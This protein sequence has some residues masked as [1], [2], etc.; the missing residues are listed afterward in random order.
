P[1]ADEAAFDEDLTFTPPRTNTATQS[2]PPPTRT[3]APIG[4][5]KSGGT[6]PGTPAPTSR[7]PDLATPPFATPIA[8]SGVGTGPR[9]V[10]SPPTTIPSIATRPAGTSTPLATPL[11]ARSTVATPPPSPVVPRPASPT[12]STNP[13]L[14]RQTA[15]TP[16]TNPTVPRTEVTPLP[17]PPVS[18]AES[19]EPSGSLD[20][21]PSMMLDVEPLRRAPTAPP[22]PPVKRPPTAPPASVEADPEPSSDA[23]TRPTPQPNAAELWARSMAPAESP[24]PTLAD[25]T[26]S[27]M[28][29][30][31]AT[32]TVRK[33]P[34][35]PPPAHLETL[36]SPFA[37]GQLPEGD[38]SYPIKRSGFGVLLKIV[39]GLGVLALGFF[40]F[41]KFYPMDD[42]TP[43]QTAAVTPPAPPE[44][45]PAPVVEAP[46]VVVDAPPATPPAPIETEQPPTPTET[47]APPTPP[48]PTETAKP[49]TKPTTKPATPTTTKPATKPTTETGSSPTT[50]ST[51][52]PTHT[53]TADTKPESSGGDCDEVGCVISKYDRP[54]CAKYKPSDTFTPKNVVPDELDRAMVKAGVEKIKPRVVACGEKNS[55]K[56]TVRLA[57]TVDSEGHVKTVTVSET[58]DTALGE[59]VAAAMR[60]ATFG[61]SVNG[62]EFNYPFVF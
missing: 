31:F 17:T 42:N 1:G 23:P 32:Q 29:N 40:A 57:V 52:T 43:T 36:G 3:P 6:S 28:A 13:A 49:P 46:A 22:P 18:A 37:P 9:P 62:G 39:L 48:T 21:S 14:P 45:A 27:T 8:R 50:E 16:V 59:C 15:N 30:L 56:G 11:S 58:P 2:M 44:P 7:T 33:R 38:F 19:P 4:V 20:I 54:C 25:S 12:P 51:P 5:V 26:E 41:V 61:K 53:E 24:K 34:P 10:V 55:N 60:A 47:P 35:T